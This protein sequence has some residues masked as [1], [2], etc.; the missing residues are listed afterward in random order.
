M[1]LP[2][3]PIHCVSHT[4]VNTQERVAAENRTDTRMMKPPVLFVRSTSD[5]G[6]ERERERGRLYSGR[7][8][9]PHQGA[10]SVNT[11][12]DVAMSNC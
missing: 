4:S 12:R 6:T 5:E 11:D 9:E 8:G 2:V 10:K 7:D 3:G 1:L